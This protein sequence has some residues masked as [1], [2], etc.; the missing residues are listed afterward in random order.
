MT[1]RSEIFLLIG[2]KRK[3]LTRVQDL[4]IESAVTRGTCLKAFTFSVRMGNGSPLEGFIRVNPSDWS[5]DLVPHAN[6]EEGSHDVKL[7]AIASDG[8]KITQ[9]IKVTVK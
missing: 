9:N 2:E 6:S 7:I 8:T 5:I 1:S 4:E 3:L